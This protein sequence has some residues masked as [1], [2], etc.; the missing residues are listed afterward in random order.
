LLHERLQGDQ[1]LVIETVE[2]PDVVNQW[3]GEWKEAVLCRLPLGVLVALGLLIGTMLLPRAIRVPPEAS[4]L[5]AA[6]HL[7]SASWLPS[8]LAI[9]I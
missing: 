5:L 9:A 6:L 3:G 1:V 2:A 7:C 4:G 8:L